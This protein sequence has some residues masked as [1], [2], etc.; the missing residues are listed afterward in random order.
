MTIPADFPLLRFVRHLSVAHH[1]PGRIRLKLSGPVDGDLKALGNQAKNFANGVSA[2]AGIRS[3]ALNPLAK[4]CT[5]EYDIQVIPASAWSGLLSGDNCP[6]SQLL[7]QSL[8][9][10]AKA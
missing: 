6:D 1:V 5:I 3:V 2:M 8:I 9:L 7:L 10:A 4:S